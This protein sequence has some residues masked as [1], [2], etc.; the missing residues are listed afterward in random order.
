[1]ETALDLRVV[2]LLAS[3]LCHDL[4]GPV[5]AIHN[6]M[7]L[8][9]EAPD[10]PAAVQDAVSLA[11][12]SARQASSLLQ[13]YRVAYGQGGRRV[14]T[15][16]DQ[17]AELARNFA[18]ARKTSITW[19]DDARWQAVTVDAAKLTLNLV[20]LAVEALPRGGAITVA[21]TPAP[22]GLPEVT[23]AGQ[24]ARLGEGN[25]AAL[26]AGVGPADLTPYTVHAYFT[27]FLAGVLDARVDADAGTDGR[28]VLRTVAQD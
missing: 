25:R 8:L 12:G 15:D 10:D 24:D 5:G 22:A 23:A 28:V 1:M 27:G 2:E 9:E 3:R 6:G 18:A 20:G 13:F 11:G 26:A 19:P 17:M 21:L 7:E 4:I 14:L 16:T